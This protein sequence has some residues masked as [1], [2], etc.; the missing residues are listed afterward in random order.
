MDWYWRTRFLNLKK[1][2]CVTLQ[3]WSL[4]ATF[5]YVSHSPYRMEKSLKSAR[6]SHTRRPVRDALLEYAGP[7]PFLVVPMLLLWSTGKYKR[8]KTRWELYWGI[9]SFETG[10]AETP[11]A[12]TFFLPE[13]VFQ[14]PASHQRPG[15]N[16]TLRR[17]RQQS[18]KRQPSYP[19]RHNCTQAALLSERVPYTPRWARSE[20]ISL[21]SQPFR[22]VR[23][24]DHIYEYS[25]HFPQCTPVCTVWNFFQKYL[26]SHFY[27]L[28][29]TSQADVWPLHYLQEQRKSNMYIPNVCLFI[30]V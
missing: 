16:Q 20:T 8:C 23:R 30:L 4:K 11:G 7:M 24:K 22:P 29:Q 19:Q 2:S 5:V 9:L 21:F 13:L 12:L 10:L 26:S 17:D 27:L 15:G 28:P 6:R 3:N 14:F 18:S 1:G 25:R